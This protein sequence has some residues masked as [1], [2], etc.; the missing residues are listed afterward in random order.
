MMRRGI[1]KK[2][3]KQRV[4]DMSRTWSVTLIFP[5]PLTT[6]MAS[7]L[8][9]SIQKRPDWWSTKYE[10]VEGMRK[11]DKL[12]GLVQGAS[13]AYAGEDLKWITEC[14]QSAGVLVRGTST[15]YG[16]KMYNI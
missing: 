11:F 5:S 9:D 4:V 16:Y 1:K 13:S 12:N 8:C 15:A 10:F 14:C 6:E 2:K 3:K 7:R